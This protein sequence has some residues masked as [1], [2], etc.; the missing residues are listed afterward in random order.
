MIAE[1]LTG[2]RVWSMDSVRQVYGE[3]SD[4]YIALFGSSGPAHPDDLALIA[5]HLSIRPG[6]VLDVGCGPGHLTEYLRLL[7][8]D[9]FGVDLVPEFIEHA[10]IAFPNGRYQLGSFLDL[11]VATDS[12]EGMLAWY[13]LIHV[14]LADLDVA[15]A[16]LRRVTKVGG[17]VVVG[18][19]EGDQIEPF[20][21]CPP[22]SNGPVSKRSN[23][24]A[25]PAP[26]K[27]AVDP[28]DR[29]QH[30]RLERLSRVLSEK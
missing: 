25:G 1:S 6:S 2:D 3:M 15:L 7:D 26:E 9:V 20:D 14:N 30:S 13:S 10:R 22:D 28:T 12:L 4:Q 21:R 8:V 23:G 27:P 19:F 18:F 24:N 11:P 29:S 17:R 16:E 5:R